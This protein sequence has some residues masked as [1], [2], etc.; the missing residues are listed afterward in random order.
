MI[1]WAGIP[2]PT[3]PPVGAAGVMR[4]ALRG[5]ALA[6][7]VFGGLG[8]LLALRGVEAGLHGARRPW[9]PHVTVAVC[10]AALALLGIARRTRG[11]RDPAAG[12]Q[13]AN[14]SSWLDIFALNAAGPTVFVAKAE[15]A[16]WP[17]IGGLARAT[18]TVFIERR[19]AEAGRQRE[20]LRARLARGELLTVFPEGTS[21]DG[22][23][24]L[25]FKTTILAAFAEAP[26]LRVQPVTVLWHAPPGLRADLYGWWGEMSFGGHA[27]RMLAAPRGGA[28][29]LVHHA[30]VAVG[31]MPDRKRLAPA[32][33]SAVASGM[34]WEPDAGC[35]PNVGR[36]P[37]ARREPE[38]DSTSPG[39]SAA[40]ASPPGARAGR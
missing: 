1:R 18:G 19:R 26:G 29:E 13:V 9:T 27:W 28:V 4:A 39:L 2:E 32:L 21:T 10:R 25:A 7:A 11:A 33:R 15:V 37:V 20:A 5:P 30:A 36:E 24:V 40:G 17:G 8:V 22:R 16:G 34:P 3:D 38:A 23:R 31:G 14:H 6:L 12:A 35:G